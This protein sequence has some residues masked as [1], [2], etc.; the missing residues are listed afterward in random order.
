MFDKLVNFIIPDN[1]NVNFKTTGKHSFFVDPTIR[2]K[3]PYQSA[4]ITIT[5]FT[6]E[7]R[8]AAQEFTC[9]WY[10][11]DEGRSFEMEDDAEAITYHVSPYDIGKTIKCLVK[12]TGRGKGWAELVFGPI[13][14]DPALISQMENNLI[15][16]VDDMS[17]EVV[18]VGSKM[19][20]WSNTVNSSISVDYT[21][22]TMNFDGF[23]DNLHFKFDK[24]N[25]VNNLKSH[26]KAET[27]D[28]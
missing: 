22:F 14:P 18:R 13:K 27:R 28:S 3:L 11:I 24:K 9:K 12:G 20:N 8:S 21:G 17:I 16:G 25:P 19:I 15:F 1:R 5:C 10:R 6:D 7:T 4:S 23:V 2:G 26:E